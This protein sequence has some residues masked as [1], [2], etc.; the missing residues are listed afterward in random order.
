[1]RLSALIIALIAT[2]CFATIFVA[3][4]EDEKQFNVRSLL[5][6]QTKYY[7][8]SAAKLQADNTI[9]VEPQPIRTL[10]FAPQNTTTTL[11]ASTY[12]NNT[13]TGEVGKTVD[14]VVNFDAVK[15]N[16]GSVVFGEEV[17]CDFSFIMV[18]H[19]AISTGV[20]K[21]TGEQYQWTIPAHDR[22]SFTIFDKSG[23]VKAVYVAKKFFLEEPKTFMQSYG[24]YIMMF[25]LMALNM[26]IQTKTKNMQQNQAERDGTAV[27][28]TP[29]ADEFVH[30]ENQ[31]NKDGNKGGANTAQNT[32]AKSKKD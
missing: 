6:E 28:A 17:Y 20:I 27:N 13:E 21:S 24:T 14:F 9:V 22:W 8:I 15:N 1:M 7:T 10:F 25:G 16:T 2:I 5:H 31:G 12:T 4:E 23:K 26:W 11:K 19:V 32:K 18:N 29:A 3:A 30:T